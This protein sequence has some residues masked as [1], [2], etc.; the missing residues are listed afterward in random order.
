MSPTLPAS[1]WAVKLRTWAVTSWSGTS[2]SDCPTCEDLDQVGDKNVDVTVACQSGPLDQV[3]ADS[4]SANEVS[5]NVALP[6]PPSISATT[7]LARCPSRPTASTYAPRLARTNAVALPIPLVEP[8]TSA[9]LPLD[10]SYDVMSSRFRMG[11][12]TQ[13][14]RLALGFQTQ[15]PC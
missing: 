12:A 14:D 2:E 7:P 8:V 10:Q 1:K 4:R 6:P 13:P 15:K 11:G 9:A 3:P 5:R